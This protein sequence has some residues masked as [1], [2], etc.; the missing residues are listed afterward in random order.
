MLHLAIQAGKTADERYA[1][2][3]AEPLLNF[4]LTLPIASGFPRV[5]VCREESVY[6]AL[7]INAVAYVVDHAHARAGGR[8]VLPPILKS[9]RAAAGRAELLAKRGCIGQMLRVC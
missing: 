8:L 3:R 1:L 5:I 2:P 6:V 7:R 9:R 4:G